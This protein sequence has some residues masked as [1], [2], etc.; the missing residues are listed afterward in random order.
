MCRNLPMA[1]T[2]Y[3][4]AEMWLLL[5]LRGVGLQPFEDMRERFGA[6]IV[7]SRGC[8]KENYSVSLSQ[9]RSGRRWEDGVRSRPIG[10]EFLF[11]ST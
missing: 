6:D 3:T 10:G 7:C 2:D 1:P 5:S 11:S 9:E 4:L 8:C